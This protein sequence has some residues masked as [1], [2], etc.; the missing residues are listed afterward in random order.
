M[1]LANG[2]V[3]GNK[4]IRLLPGRLFM[5]NMNEQIWDDVKVDTPF[6]D[7]KLLILNVSFR[8]RGRLY[9]ILLFM[10]NL[11]YLVSITDVNRLAA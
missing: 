10:V 9:R 3:Y 4:N 7:D 8:G 1:N 11:R 6:Q 5:Y 2:G